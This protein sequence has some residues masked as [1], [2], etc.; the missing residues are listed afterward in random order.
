MIM[1]PGDFE[2]RFEITTA[3]ACEGV[4]SVVSWISINVHLFKG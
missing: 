3:S 4:D 2:L 1:L